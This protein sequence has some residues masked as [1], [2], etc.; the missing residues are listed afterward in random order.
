MQSKRQIDYKCSLCDKVYKK[1]SKLKEHERTHT[2][3][4][5]TPPPLI[6]IIIICI[7]Q[8]YRDLLSVITLIAVKHILDPHIS[9]FI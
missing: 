6:F 1:P 7:D 4:V 5:N 3:E 9:K 8:S 2:G